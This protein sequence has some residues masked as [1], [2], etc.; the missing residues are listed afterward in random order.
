MSELHT[1]TYSSNF[2]AKLIFSHGLPLLFYID[3]SF[4]GIISIN[5]N[6]WNGGKV[7]GT[8]AQQKYCDERS[9]ELAVASPNGQ[10]SQVNKCPWKPHGHDPLAASEVST[11]GAFPGGD[12]GEL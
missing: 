11:K 8:E 12:W 7:R 3:N 4:M 9:M 5:K 6:S 1:T 10:R 2:L